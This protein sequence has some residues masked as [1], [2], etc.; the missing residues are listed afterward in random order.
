MVRFVPVALIVAM[1]ASPA[2]SQPGGPAANKGNASAVPGHSPKFDIVDDKSTLPT[3]HRNES[4]IFA[5]TELAPNAVVGIGMF[6]FKSEKSLHSPVTA[7][8]LDTTRRR[9]AAVGFSLRF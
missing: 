6:G 2:W 9:K 7:R 1:A 5:G 3:V 4:R 8:D